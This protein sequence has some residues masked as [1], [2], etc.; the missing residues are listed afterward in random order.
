M[1]TAVPLSSKVQP[2]RS[3]ALVCPP[4]AADVTGRVNIAS[5]LPPSMGVV[6]LAVSC[7]RTTTV[8]PIWIYLQL[9]FVHLASF[10]LPDKVGAQELQAVPD[11]TIESK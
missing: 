8:F 1:N 9:V 3:I 5:A 6:V 4:K 7:N 11:P 10:N 2:P